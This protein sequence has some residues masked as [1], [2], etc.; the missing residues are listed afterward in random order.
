VAESIGDLATN[1]YEAMRQSVASLGQRISTSIDEAIHGPNVIA[2]KK[3]S[4]HLGQK[5]FIGRAEACV[6][7]IRRAHGPP[8]P[9]PQPKWVEI[10][11]GAVSAEI[12]NFIFIIYYNSCTA[13][14]NVDIHMIFVPITLFKMQLLIL[15]INNNAYTK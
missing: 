4:A 11:G 7:K 5:R 14:H 10:Y 12:P 15:I 1:P 3:A 9:L 13:L 6:K 8:A 2:A